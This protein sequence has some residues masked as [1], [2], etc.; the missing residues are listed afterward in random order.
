[1]EKQFHTSSDCQ[2]L[3]HIFQSSAINKHVDPWNN[4]SKLPFRAIIFFH[5]PL[6]LCDLQIKLEGKKCPEPTAA[7][8]SLPAI[9]N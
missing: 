6:C 9:Q 8:L 5:L 2:H 7:V 4:I 1:M 3:F